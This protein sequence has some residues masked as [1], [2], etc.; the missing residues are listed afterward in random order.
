MCL[1]GVCMRVCVCDYITIL[2]EQMLCK[3][4]LACLQ[5]PAVMDSSCVVRQTKAAILQ[6]PYYMP[7][8]S[9]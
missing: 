8:R 9:P 2:V 4:T 7:S 5:W 1:C 6:M 3:A